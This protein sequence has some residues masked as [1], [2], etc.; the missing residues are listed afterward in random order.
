MTDPSWSRVNG[1]I[2]HI[3]GEKR[4]SARFDPR[5]SE[6]QRQ[7]FE[8]LILLCPKHHK[9]VDW[10]EPETHPP[11]LLRGMKDRHHE[12]CR[13]GWASDADL[14][15]FAVLT[16]LETEGNRVPPTLVL[17]NKGVIENVGEGS[18][19]DIVVEHVGGSRAGLTIAQDLADVTLI[20][21]DQLD[22]LRYEPVGDVDDRALIRITWKDL[23]GNTFEKTV[24]L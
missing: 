24:G 9:L 18:A 10:L 2:A 11:H 16:L 15:R 1:E 22:A 13:G 6:A 20:D 17:T 21:G 12:A 5:M 8:N 3:E 4:G 14:D 19:T 23:G 7:A